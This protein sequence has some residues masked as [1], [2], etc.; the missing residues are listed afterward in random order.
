MDRRPGDPVR[1][2]SGR[3]W[4]LPSR[5]TSART[6]RGSGL[7]LRASRGSFIPASRASFVA[8]P[9]RRPADR[10]R[11]RAK[12]GGRRPLCSALR[13]A[14]REPAVC[15]K[16][17]ITVVRWYGL[18]GNGENVQVSRARQAWVPMLVTCSQRDCRGGH[19]RV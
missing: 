7:R 13:H 12:V 8:C 4:S 18:R 2:T 19:G 1:P 9:L 15:R 5:R 16:S 10:R 6:R 14:H 17:G 11:G 3:A